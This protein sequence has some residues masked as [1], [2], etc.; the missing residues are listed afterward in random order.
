MPPPGG[1]YVATVDGTTAMPADRA[2]S[3]A[4]GM[5]FAGFLMLPWCARSHC[6]LTASVGAARAARSHALTP[7]RSRPLPR[8]A[9]VVAGQHLALLAARAPRRGGHSR[10][11]APPMCARPKPAL[12][13][14]RAPLTPLSRLACLPQTRGAAR[15]APPSSQCCCCRGRWGSSSPALRSLG[16]TPGRCS[17]SR[18]GRP[19]T[20]R[21]DASRARGV[22]CVCCAGSWATLTA[23]LTLRAAVLRS[24]KDAR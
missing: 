2:R 4:R 20:R 3:L 18:A 5:F 10:P 19:R 17:P 13:V 22:G 7:V 11:R 16:S 24:S 14:A 1:G 23:A 15:W 21:R 8:C 9:Q 6:C 12:I